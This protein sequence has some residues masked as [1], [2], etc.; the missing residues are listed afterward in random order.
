[1]NIVPP[2]P[3]PLSPELIAKFKAIV[4]DKYG[5]TDQNEIAA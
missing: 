1:M 4:G 2:P 5:V 3:A